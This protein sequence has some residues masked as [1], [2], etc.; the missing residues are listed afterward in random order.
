[1]NIKFIIIVLICAIILAIILKYA[2]RVIATVQE[3]AFLD[4][5]KSLDDA[6]RAKGQTPTHSNVEFEALSA[7]I[8]AANKPWY[9]I[10][11]T[12]SVESVM[13]VMRNELDLSL[14]I[15]AFGIKD[16]M[17][18]AAYL[19]DFLSASEIEQY[20]NKP[21]RGNGVKFQF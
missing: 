9:E 2:G 6:A 19:Y 20:V 5:N 15:K 13:Q 8:Q 18:L 12:Y 16:G 17:A 10:D 7:K 11:D 1:M 3:K 4:K 14:L 21:L